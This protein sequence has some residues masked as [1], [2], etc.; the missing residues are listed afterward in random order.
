M[1]VVGLYMFNTQNASL[2]RANS[3][4]RCRSQMW[5]RLPHNLMAC[6]ARKSTRTFSFYRRVGD[7]SRIVVLVSSCLSRDL[8]IQRHVSSCRPRVAR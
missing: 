1:A 8:N 7:P 2:L 6:R 5:S 4:S 3:G